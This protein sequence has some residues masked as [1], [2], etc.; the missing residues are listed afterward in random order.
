[1]KSIAF[2]IIC[3]FILGLVSCKGGRSSSPETAYQKCVDQGVQHLLDNSKPNVDEKTKKEF[4]S[5]AETSCEVIKK[6]CS[7]STE[8]DKQ[9]CQGLMERYGVSDFAEDLVGIWV[10]RNN[11]L[12]VTVRGT[13]C[14]PWGQTPSP[15][16]PSV[17]ATPTRA[18]G[19][20][21]NVEMRTTSPREPGRSR[22]A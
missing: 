2:L 20:D 19:V 8:I 6:H 21:A 18:G 1:M 16:M 4:K 9:S 7:G 12:S 14:R 11:E 22:A 15:G 10:T 5:M 3:S 13:R 17:A